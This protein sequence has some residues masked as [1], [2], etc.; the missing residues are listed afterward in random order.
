M[1]VCEM[2]RDISPTARWFGVYLAPDSTYNG[3]PE[4]MGL[5]VTAVRGG[6]AVHLSISRK[7]E[8]NV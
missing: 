8:G 6:Y 4:W 1:Y 3:Q 5:K 2:A 7:R